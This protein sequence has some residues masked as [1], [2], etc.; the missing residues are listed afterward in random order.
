VLESL[1]EG[2]PLVCIP[3]GNDQPGVASRVATHG[4]GI[5][6]PPRR[7]SAERL[8]SAVRAVREDESYRNAARRLQSAMAQINGPDLAADI[9]EDVLKIR[10][11][12]RAQT[13]N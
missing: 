7:A 3:L 13:L 8:R 10:M 2:V 1:A 4:A 9:V 6:V 12:A 5:V 11:G